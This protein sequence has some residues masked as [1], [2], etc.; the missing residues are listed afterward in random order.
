MNPQKKMLSMYIHNIN[1]LMTGYEYEEYGE[2]VL[3]NQ[4]NLQERTRH[5][6]M[7]KFLGFFI[8]SKIQLQMLLN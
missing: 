6:L 3:A 7:I 2:F 5:R 1:V 8:L 4:Q